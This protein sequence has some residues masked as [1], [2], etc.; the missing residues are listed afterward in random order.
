MI[1]LCGLLQVK[2]SGYIICLSNIDFHVF[3]VFPTRCV[4]WCL[5]KVTVQ[6]FVVALVLG[7]VVIILK[8]IYYA[9][10]I[11]YIFFNVSVACK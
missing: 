10:L 8:V 4:L 6:F 2:D 7:P 5:T 11:L 9:K 1:D 3:A